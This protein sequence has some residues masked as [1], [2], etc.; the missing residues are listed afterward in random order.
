MYP[1]VGGAATQVDIFVR[2]LGQADLWPD[3][4]PS[5]RLQVRLMFLSDLWV[6]LTFGQMY[7]PSLRLQVRLTFFVRSLGQADL[8]SDVSPTRDI[9]WPGALLLWSGDL[10]SDV[11]PGQIHL[12]AKCYTTAICVGLTCGQMSLKMRLWVRLTFGHMYCTRHFW[13]SVTLLHLCVRLTFD[14]MCPQWAETSC[15]QVWYYFRSGW[16]V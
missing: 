6:R 2:S 3:L 1:H 12:V 15:D 7:P 5:L 8:W 14:Q 13:P 10:L 16:T 11:P 4:P 9:L